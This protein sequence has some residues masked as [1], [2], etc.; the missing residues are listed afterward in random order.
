MTKFEIFLL[1]I[2][3]LAAFD[4]TALLALLFWEKR[5]SK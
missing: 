4:L 2:L 3:A 5:K 1:A